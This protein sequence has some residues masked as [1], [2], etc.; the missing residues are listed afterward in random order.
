MKKLSQLKRKHLN[1]EREMVREAL[2][3]KDWR[4]HR[5]AQLLG[6]S[7]STLKSVITRLGLGPEYRE[8]NPGPGKR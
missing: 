5:A 3:Q 2:E 4:L 6:V 8:K 1:E 7:D